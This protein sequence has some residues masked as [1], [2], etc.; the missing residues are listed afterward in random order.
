[1]HN[2]ITLMRK[3]LRRGSVLDLCLNLLFGVW[4]LYFL[5]TGYIIPEPLLRDSGKPAAAEIQE[6]ELP[7]PPVD[8]TDDR[9]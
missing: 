1:M 5:A 4:A 8:L 6:E 9:A 3:R 7:A 2:L